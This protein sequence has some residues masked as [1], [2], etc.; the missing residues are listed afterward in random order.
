MMDPAQLGDPPIGLPRRHRHGE[1]LEDA[2]TFIGVGDSST[3]S[4]A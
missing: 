3:V 4:Q 2:M 1:G